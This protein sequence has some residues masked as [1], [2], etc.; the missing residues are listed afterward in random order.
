MAKMSNEN[1][2]TVDEFATRKAAKYARKHNVSTREAKKKLKE[3]A[4]IL[5][6]C[7][8]L[9]RPVETPWGSGYYVTKVGRD[10][11]RRTSVNAH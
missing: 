11:F 10:R 9:H 2:I 1:E 6:N 4:S 3:L 5:L 7:M 8:P